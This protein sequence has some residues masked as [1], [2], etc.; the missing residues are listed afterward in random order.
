MMSVRATRDY[1]D[2]SSEKIYQVKP[3][4]KKNQKNFLESIKRDLNLKLD[5]I[6]NVSD[7]H[8]YLDNGAFISFFGL[9]FLTKQTE[10]L[11]YKI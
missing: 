8:C 4:N 6:E 10:I 9:T 1:W 5:F 7:V 11:T 3:Q 2:S